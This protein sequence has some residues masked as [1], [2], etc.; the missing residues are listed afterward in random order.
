LVLASGRAHAGGCEACT[1]SAYCETILSPALCVRYAS[2]QGCPTD[3]AYCCPGQGC[4]I[5]SNGRPTCEPGGC[6]V[7]EEADSGAAGAGGAGTGGANTGGTSG[8]GGANA[9][10]AG[11]AS[12]GGTGTAGTGTGGAN[13]GGSAGRGNAGATSGGRASSGGA[14]PTVD[15]AVPSEGGPSSAAAASGDEGSCGC[16]VPGKRD[17]SPPLALL[18]AWAILARRRKT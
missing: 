12:S 17:G 14:S 5:G 15:A 6:V 18:V 9:G 3:Q 13:V 16:S 7:V 4:G 11:G 1:S 10:G 2:G 8:A